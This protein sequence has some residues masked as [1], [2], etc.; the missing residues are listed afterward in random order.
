MPFIFL[1]SMSELIEI[2]LLLFKKLKP[3]YR[4]FYLTD[5]RP[6]LRNIYIRLKESIKTENVKNQ[7]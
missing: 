6:I 4:N 7:T 1:A 2:K 3:I 5:F